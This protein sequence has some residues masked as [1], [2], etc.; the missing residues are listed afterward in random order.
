M[1]LILV[2]SVGRGG[3]R[4]GCEGTKRAWMVDEMGRRKMGRKERERWGWM[5]V[6]GVSREGK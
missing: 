2:L 1:K 3:R 6:E 5:K 4:R